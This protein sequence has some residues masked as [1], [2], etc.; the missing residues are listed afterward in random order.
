MME[1]KKSGRLEPSV[2]LP[3][4]A[5]K[6]NTSSRLV[7]L[8]L[9][10][11]TVALQQEAEMA[12]QG[13]IQSA[14]LPSLGS[15]AATAA[16]GGVGSGLLDDALVPA[17]VRLA[18]SVTR[19]KQACS[20]FLVS[21]ATA[22]SVCDA[23]EQRSLAFKRRYY[24]LQAE[25]RQQEVARAEFPE[26]GQCADQHS[27]SPLLPSSSPTTSSGAAAATASTSE[28]A[29]Q[30]TSGGAGAGA[31]PNAG[32]LVNGGAGMPNGTAASQQQQQALENSSSRWGLSL[33]PG[34]RPNPDSLAMLSSLLAGLHEHLRVHKELSEA[35]MTDGGAADVDGM[36]AAAAGSGRPRA[37][38]FGQPPPQQVLHPYQIDGRVLAADVL[39]A[40][41]GGTDTAVGPTRV[42]GSG[43]GGTGLE[44]QSQRRQQKNMLMPYGPDNIVKAFMS[45]AS[46]LSSLAP[47]VTQLAMAGENAGPPPLLQPPSHP[48]GHAA[49]VA[50]Q[51]QVHGNTSRQIAQLSRK[52]QEQAVAYGPV[53]RA[54]RL[55][56]SRGI[57]QRSL[58]LSGHDC[59]LDDDVLDIMTSVPA[60]TTAGQRKRAFPEL[61]QPQAPSLS[62]RSAIIDRPG[63]GVPDSYC[64]VERRTLGRDGVALSFLHKYGH[65]R[66]YM[67]SGSSACPS[68]GAAAPVA[69]TAL[70]TSTTAAPPPPMDDGLARIHARLRSL[71]LAAAS[72][73]AAA[74]AAA[75]AS[76]ATNAPAAGGQAVA[77]ST[78]SPLR[79][80][81]WQQ[82]QQGPLGS[83]EAGMFIMQQQQQANRLGE[84]D[85]REAA[86]GAT[87]ASSHIDADVSST[88]AGP[89]W[90]SMPWF[91]GTHAGSGA[92]DASSQAAGEL[93]LSLA[94]ATSGGELA[95]GERRRF[96][97]CNLLDDDD[98]DSKDGGH[99]LSGSHHRLVTMF[100]PAGVVGPM[101]GAS[102]QSS[103]ETIRPLGAGGGGTGAA[104]GALHVADADDDFGLLAAEGELVS[105]ALMFG[106]AMAAPPPSNSPRGAAGSAGVQAGLLFG[107]P[108]AEVSSS[109][110][111]SCGGGV[112]AT[113]LGDRESD[114]DGR[115]TAATAKVAVSYCGSAAPQCGAGL[116]SMMQ[117][118][119]SGDDVVMADN[120]KDMAPVVSPLGFGGKASASL[121][122]SWL[123]AVGGGPGVA[124]GGGQG[125][126]AS[127]LFDAFGVLLSPQQQ[128]Q[129]H[130]VP[131]GNINAFGRLQ[132]QQAQQNG[133]VP[134]VAAMAVPLAPQQPQAAPAVMGGFGAEILALKARMQA[135]MTK[136]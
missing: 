101:M 61:V 126:K 64:S 40:A 65:E 36:D 14:Y 80:A 75:A 26:G 5:L 125:P 85:F 115:T 57:S 22:S 35:L 59:C 6:T 46:L 113:D 68:G 112:S 13:T 82:Q 53:L 106:S 93:G 83:L 66:A 88:G 67:A 48:S 49:H 25:I 72:Q 105:Q 4:S 60:V 98:Y 131:I 122:I 33:L 79:G 127:S 34:S 76:V 16:G 56:S 32:D 104:H 30:T 136:Q 54:L 86:A 96:D 62:R 77:S 84:N 99:G 52:V 124:P 116:G 3:V 9:E 2:I 121:S 95:S 50:H 90:P 130:Q 92:A 55:E 108:L 102:P 29:S 134:A 74:T 10:L 28:P 123:G 133:A 42:G 37:G 18:V 63:C 100:P 128:P 91:G 7:M 44:Q 110:W 51:L 119:D 73:P 109:G 47:H 97:L 17:D 114:G 117:D 103:L 70:A 45:F 81:L 94:A 78:V 31:G 21:A 107:G 23:M 132:Q 89:V 87:A 41:S 58:D 15:S 1:L 24:E 111:G 27:S 20:D 120:D 129:Q 12:C 11:S 38:G 135:A 71:N 69:K 8:L 39:S 118:T 43:S 19:A